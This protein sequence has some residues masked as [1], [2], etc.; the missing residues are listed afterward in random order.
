MVYIPATISSSIIPY[1]FL[2]FLSIQ[3]AWKGFEDI[4]NS[5]KY[6]YQISIFVPIHY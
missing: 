6:E 3:L 1:E 2:I 5:K 4:K